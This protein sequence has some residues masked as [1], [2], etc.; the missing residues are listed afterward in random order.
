MYCFCASLL[1]HLGLL[2]IM[3]DKLK[4]IYEDF[5]KEKDLVKSL[6]ELEELRVKYLGKKS[7]FTNILKNIGKSSES[8]RPVF[9]RLS[10]DLRNFISKSL[11]DKKL[12]ISKNELKEKLQ[13]EKIDVTEPGKRQPLGYVHP[14]SLVKQSMCSIFSSMGFSVV[15]GPEIENDYYNF[16][17]L[18][19]PPFHPSR[20]TQDTFYLNDG[21]LLRTQTTS[22]QVRIMEKEEPPIRMICPG[23]VFRADDIDSTH[24]PIFHQLEGLVVDRNVTFSDLKGTLEYF[25]KEF[26]GQSTKVRFRPH[27]FP[28]TEPSA[29]LDIECFN[30]KGKGCRLCKEEG[31]IEL[32]G[33]GMVHQKVL[34]RCNINPEVY[35]GFAFGMGIERITMM[36]YNI[37]DI[38]LFYENDIRFLKQFA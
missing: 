29:E 10:N 18:N 3:K 8:E 35:S 26:Y 38:R 34:K 1:D 12:E 13:N 11:K 37:N 5:I 24:S 7:E 19:M 14:L 20:D 31:Y 2:I 15:D 28:Y 36:K 4:K 32:L 16:E 22:V 17:A 6:K 21:L 25:I 23:K 33:C 27:N 9:G 30:C